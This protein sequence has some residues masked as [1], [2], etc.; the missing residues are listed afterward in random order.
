MIKRIYQDKHMF[1]NTFMRKLL[2]ERCALEIYI[3]V[4]D[5][6]KGESRL[7]GHVFELPLLA[8][9]ASVDRGTLAMP[10]SLG[11]GLCDAAVRV[12]LRC[13]AFYATVVQPEVAC[14]DHISI[15]LWAGS[16]DLL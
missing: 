7:S 9:A 13:T 1:T 6:C 10:G 3:A 16:Q 2:I 12:I 11:H 4:R 15:R 8:M 14:Q 5:A